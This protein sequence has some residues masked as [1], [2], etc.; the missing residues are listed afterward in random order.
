VRYSLKKLRLSSSV[1]HSWLL[2]YALIIVISLAA[3]VILYFQSSSVISE[4]I[5]KANSA[6]LKQVS[7]DL[8]TRMAEIE[9]LSMQLFL[10][11]RLQVLVRAT[12]PLTENQQYSIYQL[13]Q[14][15]KAYNATNGFINGFYIYIPRIRQAI[16]YDGAYS[17]LRLH[18]VFHRNE[19]DYVDW[20][21]IMNSPHSREFVALSRREATSGERTFGYLQSFPLGTADP[22]LAN[23]VVLVKESQLRQMLSNIDWLKQGILLIVDKNNRLITSSSPHVDV[24]SLKLD[25]LN[26]PGFAYQTLDG[27]QMAISYYKS[28]RSDW[29]Y[30]A[31]A[32]SSTIFNKLELIREFAL[33]CLLIGIVLSCLAAL[34][35]ARRNYNPI[36]GLMALFSGSETRELNAGNL[37]QQRNEFQVIREMISRTLNESSRIKEELNEHQEVLRAGFLTRLIKGRTAGHTPLHDSLSAFNMSFETD[38][39]SVIVI[40]LEH[41]G[42]FGMIRDGSSTAEPAQLASF[43]LKNVFEELCRQHHEGWVTEVDDLLVCLINLQL[44]TAN[45]GKELIRIANSAQ[46]FVQ[47][48]FGIRFTAAAGRVVKSV[49]AIPESYSQAIEALEHKFVMGGGKIILFDDLQPASNNNYYFPLE[50]EQQLMNSIKIGDFA[51]AQDVVGEIFD[52]NLSSISL[53]VIMIKCLLFDMTSTVVKTLDELGLAGGNQLLEEINPVDR[54][55]GCEN[56]FQMREEMSAILQVVCSY[57]ESRK[58]SHNIGLKETVEAY[59]ASNY[60][61]LNLSITWLADRL[62]MNASYLSRFYKEQSGESLVDCINRKRIAEAKLFLKETDL[63]MNDIAEKVGFSSNISFIRSFKRYEG[64]TPGKYKDLL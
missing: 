44:E 29:K 57:V 50:K 19:L 42:K 35:F 23:L 25:S 39:F 14:D 40:H 2:S 3:G 28:E 13:V 12:P 32:P 9:R 34:Y 54:M 46:L 21:R 31:I 16:A 27:K 26:G 45:N 36:R 51:S 56:V 4:E 47:E 18:E 43:I 33:L 52:R 63:N 22:A 17:D 6:L 10:N 48:K 41:Y 37:E 61:D 64:I 55:L 59:V 1:F 7:Q 30:I 38:Y 58:K 24:S 11:S 49:K 62:N 60:A 5:N 8:D 15:F 53:S 20:Q